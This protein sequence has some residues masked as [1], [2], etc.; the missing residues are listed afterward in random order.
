[1]K[2]CVLSLLI[3]SAALAA[4]AG[5]QEE[6]AI[7]HFAGVCEEEGYVASTWGWAI[8]VEGH[9]MA[10][11]KDPEKWRADRQSLPDRVKI[12]VLPPEKM[13]F[14]YER[15]E[16]MPRGRTPIDPCVEF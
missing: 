2:F 4:C 14:A 3:A 12:Q 9:K 1:M 8:C 15:K 5:R 6:K 7:P 11:M 16:H 10:W 13:P